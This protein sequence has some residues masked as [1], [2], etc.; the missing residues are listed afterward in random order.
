MYMVAKDEEAARR[1]RK[2]LT[3]H[4]LTDNSRFVDMS[5]SKTGLQISRS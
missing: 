3:D 2:M 1:I 5:V 4:P